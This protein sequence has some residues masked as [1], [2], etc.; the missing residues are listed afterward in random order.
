MI[1]H[2]PSLW[3]FMQHLKRLEQ[4]WTCHIK[5]MHCLN[6]LIAKYR[7]QL[8]SKAKSNLINL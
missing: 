2:L 7:Q 6:Q 5:Q 3:L 4:M 1:P 8:K